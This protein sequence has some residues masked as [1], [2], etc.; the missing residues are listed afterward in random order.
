MLT[1][2]MPLDDVPV[3]FVKVFAVLFGLAWGS[4]ATVA[5]GRIPQGLSVV[6]PG[7]RCDG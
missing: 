1:A 4:F 3:A 7:S 6:S 5:I 2:R